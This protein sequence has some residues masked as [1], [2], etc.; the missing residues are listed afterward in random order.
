MA[1]ATKRPVDTLDVLEEFGPPNFH[2]NSPIFGEEK[3]SALSRSTMYVQLSRWE[4]LSISILEAM[5]IGVPCVIGEGCRWRRY[6]GRTTWDS[7][8]RRIPTWRHVRSSPRSISLEQLRAW[9]ERSRAY[10][11]EN[12]RRR[13]RRTHHYRL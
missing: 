11:I 4:A 1:F 5:A 6:S 13:A 2:V 10:V 12:F 7:S 9:S 8:F 3:L